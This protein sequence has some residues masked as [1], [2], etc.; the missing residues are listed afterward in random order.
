MQSVPKAV[1]ITLGVLALSAAAL[2][3]SFGFKIGTSLPDHAVLLADTREGT[4]VTI[5]CVIRGS[6]DRPYVANVEAVIADTEEVWYEPFL[7]PTT[8]GASLAAGM[9]PDRSCANVGGFV[10]LQPWLFSVLN[11]GGERVAADGTVLW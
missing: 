3:M 5:P 9:R 4:Y 6:V 8:R 2:W 11:L 10:T 1:K 7:E